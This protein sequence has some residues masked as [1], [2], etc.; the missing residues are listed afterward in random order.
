[1]GTIDNLQNRGTELVNAP[2]NY[3]KR[4]F[5]VF[6]ARAVAL[7]KKGAVVTGVGIVGVGMFIAMRGRK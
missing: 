7:A 1:M 6:K 5:Q 4:K 3:M 2:E